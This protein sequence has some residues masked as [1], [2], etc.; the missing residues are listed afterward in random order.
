MIL[1]HSLDSVA[2]V[3]GV[4]YSDLLGVCKIIIDYLNSLNLLKQHAPEVVQ[5]FFINTTPI[6]VMSTKP[7]EFH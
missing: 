7:L 3:R 2:D 1:Q 4:P 6:N 5:T